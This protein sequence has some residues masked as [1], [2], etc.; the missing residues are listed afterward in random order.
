LLWY[1]GANKRWLHADHQ[2][3]VVAVTAPGG[4]ALWINAY[5][6]YGIPKATNRGRFQF[7]GQAWIPTL[8]MYHYKARVY[9]PTLGRFLQVDPI[10]YDDQVNLYA[11]VGNDP[12][13]KMDPDGRCGTGSRIAG[14]DYAGCRVAEGF[15]D[16]ARDNPG[17]IQPQK[18][19][20]ESTEGL[21]TLKPTEQIHLA[22]FKRKGERNRAAKPDG[23]PKPFKKIRS[24][25]DKPGWVKYKDQNGKSKERPGTPDELEHLSR[26]SNSLKDGLRTIVPFG[27]GFGICVLAP[28]TCP[29]VDVDDN[30]VLEFDDW[31]NY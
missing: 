5:D 13:N 24:H 16:L 10:G 28:S 25:P 9:S 15:R 8:G 7:T 6:E 1:D 30:G 21:D 22:G 2:G 29:L 23:T 27:A 26:G 14:G 12:V 17:R 19:V 31:E 18:A 20:S 11:Y 4:G 3:S